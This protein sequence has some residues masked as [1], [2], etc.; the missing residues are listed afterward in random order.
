MQKHKIFVIMPFQDEFFEAYEMIKSH[1]Q[2]AF[3]FSNAATE[4]NQQNILADIIR[5]LHEADV[6]LA[7]LTGLNPNVMYELGVAHSLNKKTIIITQNDLSSLPFDLKQYRTK[8]YNTHYKQFFE[9]LEYLRKHFYGAVDGSVSFSNP[10]SDFQT[11]I[12]L[13]PLETSKVL[14]IEDEKDKGFLDFLAEI[15]EYGLQMAANL[16]EMQNNMNVMT[17]N[18]TACSAQIERVK[19]KGGSGVPSFVRKE[20][21]KTASFINTFSQQL[22]VHNSKNDVLWTNIETNLLGLLENPFATTEENLSGMIATL[23]ELLTLKQAILSSKETIASL[24]ESNQ[25]LMGIE[26]SLNQSIRFLNEDLSTYITVSEQM[27]AGIDRILV[28]SKFIVGD[29]VNN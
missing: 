6:V 1:F 14:P 16:Q 17:D 22:K 23:K 19:S 3:D 18:V 20:T 8:R 24:K 11:Q 21:K 29:I 4:D 25:Q 15:D 27:I 26:R 12:G 28:K 7:D 9:L 2:D 10:I 5:P 13:T